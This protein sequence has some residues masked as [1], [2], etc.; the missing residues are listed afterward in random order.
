MRHVRA[1]ADLFERDCRKVEHAGAAHFLHAVDLVVVAAGLLRHALIRFR[2]QFVAFAAHGGTHR[3]GF[4]AGGLLALALPVVAHVALAH[5]RQ[6]LV[7]FVGGHLERA[8]L[9]AIAA[10]HAFV[11]VVDHRSQRGLLQCAHRAHGG[12]GRLLAVHAQ[13]AAV[14][15]AVGFHRRQLVGRDGLFRGDLVVVRQPPA[16]GAA[17]FAGFAADAKGAVVQYGLRHNKTLNSFLTENHAKCVANLYSN[18]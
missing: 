5:L 4:G 6:A 11:G 1:Q 13:A 10:S 14:A 15:F 18:V 8:G 3:T 7:P 17:A 9:H 16:L 12:A 2:Q